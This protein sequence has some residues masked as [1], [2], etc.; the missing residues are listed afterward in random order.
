MGLTYKSLP[1]SCLQIA[2]TENARKIVYYPR[3]H[4]VILGKFPVKRSTWSNITRT[5]T[6]Y[7]IENRSSMHM[8]QVHVPQVSHLFLIFTL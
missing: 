1:F 3:Y 2:W 7:M 8:R 4:Y 5:D 6:Y